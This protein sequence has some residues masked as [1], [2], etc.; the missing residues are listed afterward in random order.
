[1][2]GS[3]GG[4]LPRPKCMVAPEVEA[5]W[6]AADFPRPAPAADSLLLAIHGGG[7]MGVGPRS[8][9]SFGT[10]I[11]QAVFPLRLF[12]CGFRRP[13][14]GPRRFHNRVFFS[15]FS[16]GFYGYYGYP[17]YYGDDFYSSAD[18][19]PSYDYYGSAYNSAQNDI[20]QQQQDIDRLEDEVA[21]LR[22]Q[23]ES[24]RGIARRPSASSGEQVSSLHAHPAGLPRQ[25]H[26]GSAELRDRR[27]HALDFQRA[28]SN[29]ASAVLAGHR[30]H[31]Q[32]QRRSRR[33]FP[34]PKIDGP[35]SL[36]SA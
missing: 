14:F 20:A 26:P 19:Y 34:N 8:G 33:R 25:A 2:R 31:H 15:T 30:G 21:R 6:D 23:R 36:V 3:A 24:E 12:L 32:S 11:H 4:V 22:E 35:V 18:N 16:P 13:G 27:R 28:A 5:R 9:A 10:G 7:S 1:M 17:A 29:Q